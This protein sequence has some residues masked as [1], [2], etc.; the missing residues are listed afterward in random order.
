MFFVVLALLLGFSQG[1]ASLLTGTALA[2]LAWN[3]FRARPGA[4]GGFDAR[5]H[6]LDRTAPG[7]PP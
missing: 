3:L 2:L 6:R 7:P 5:P 1:L 4:G